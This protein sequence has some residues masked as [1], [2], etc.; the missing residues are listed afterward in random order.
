M[1]DTQ[2]WTRE[3]LRHGQAVGGIV[4]DTLRRGHTRPECPRCHSS[5]TIAIVR[6]EIEELPGHPLVE[7]RDWQCRTCHSVIRETI[8][9]A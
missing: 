8:P 6:I 1:I 4:R 3:W 5:R 2:D 9:R 7:Q